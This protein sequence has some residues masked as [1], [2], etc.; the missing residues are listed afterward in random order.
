M[1]LRDVCKV[2]VASL[3]RPADDQLAHVIDG[4]E[5]A[6]DADDELGVHILEFA[7]GEVHVGAAHRSHDLHDGDAICADLV[8]VHVDLDFPFIA[9]GEAH[10]GDAGDLRDPRLNAVFDELVE[11]A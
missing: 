9:S 8:R 1:D 10:L 5:F 3:A 11:F 4:L 7:G 6:G 2:D